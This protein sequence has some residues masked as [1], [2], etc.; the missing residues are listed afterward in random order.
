MLE[1]GRVGGKALNSI[2]SGAYRDDGGNFIAFHCSPSE[3]FILA[4]EK[5]PEKSGRLG[6]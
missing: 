2:H 3:Y 4:T 5:Q 6:A 1:A